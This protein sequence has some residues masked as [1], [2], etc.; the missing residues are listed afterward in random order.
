M[1]DDEEIP[2]RRGEVPTTPSKVDVVNTNGVATMTMAGKTQKKSKVPPSTTALDERHM[3]RT[4][5]KDWALWEAFA[6]TLGF[7]GAGPWVRQQA[8]DA[9]ATAIAEMPKAKRDEI[10]ATAKRLMAEG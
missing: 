2:A 6:R 5:S 1:I 7:N 4:S 3:I 9:L 8:N 10:E